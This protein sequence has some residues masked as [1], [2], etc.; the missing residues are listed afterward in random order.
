MKAIVYTHYGPPEVLQL[1]EV[2]KPAP[3]ENEVL[4]KILAASANPAD[5]HLIEGK[6]FLAR[7]IAGLP[8][9][10][11]PFPGHDFAGRV[12]AVGSGVA[13]FKPGDDVFGEIMG[14]AFAEYVCMTEDKVALKPANISYEGAAS[15]PMV[16]FTA[17]QG[18]RDFAHLQAGQKVLINGA[19]GGIGTFAVQYARSIGADVTGVCSTKNVDLVK[20]LGASQVIDYTRDDFSQTGQQYDVI[21]CT[22][23]NRSAAAYRRALKPGGVCIVAGFTTMPHMLVQ[24]MLLGSLLSLAGSRKIGGM[25]TAQALPADLRLIKDLLESGTVVPVIDRRYPLSETAEAIRY[26]ETGRAR[27]KVIITMDG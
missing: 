14:G 18:L 2:A 27:G 7:I 19:S 8:R 24:V 5:W 10:K 17:I 25:G 26:L 16:G 3:K 22:V 4:V 1:K 21:Y 11:N 6:P 9:P 23:G 12:E 20:S 13:Q 15:V